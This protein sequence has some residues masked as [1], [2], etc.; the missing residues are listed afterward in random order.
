MDCSNFYSVLVW[1]V[2]VI[3]FQTLSSGRSAS[4]YH[5]WWIPQPENVLETKRDPVWNSLRN[6]SK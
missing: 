6:Q 5:K 1:K 2:V 3:G 4:D